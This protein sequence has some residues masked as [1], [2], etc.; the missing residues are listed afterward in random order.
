MIFTPRITTIWTRIALGLFLSSAICLPATL[1]QE[2]T[3]IKFATSD[4]LSAWVFDGGDWT[5]RDNQLLQDKPG[6]AHA[7]LKDP[8]FSDVSLSVEFFVFPD[9]T[10]V[11]APGIIFRSPDSDS[12]YGVHFDTLHDSVILWR[13]PYVKNDWVVVKRVKANLQ[14]N[15]CHTAGVEAKGNSLQVTLNGQQIIEATDERYPEGIV[16][17][18]TSQ[19][20]VAFRNLRVSGTP[21]KL[22]KGWKMVPKPY[23]IVCSDGGGGGYEAFP[24]LCRLKNGDLLCVFYEGYGHVSHP[25]EQL[26]RGGR[27]C[28]VRSTDEG[29]TW[30]KAEI[31]AD[32]PFDD[33]DPHIAQ[34]SDGTMIC[35]F[36]GPFA[37]GGRRGEPA[38]YITTTRSTDNG[39]TWSAPQPLELN[40]S[41]SWACSAPA[42]ELPDKSLIMGIYHEQDGVAFGGTIKSYDG[43]KTWT[44]LVHIGEGAGVYLDAETDVVLLADGRLLAALRSSKQDMYYSHSS[45]MGKTWSP[46][47]SFGFKGHAPYFLKTSTGILLVAHRV[48]STALHYSLDDGKTWSDAIIIDTVGGA[49]PSMAELSDGTI[50]CVYYEEGPGSNIRGRRFRATKSG[51]EFLQPQL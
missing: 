14:E 1:A 47:A 46:V 4:D 5:I 16:G 9:G 10:G 29:K 32:T 42:R 18:Y 3:L 2:P 35:N 40:T 41:I 22:S 7:F 15:V 50:Y 24:D 27:V 51:I 44:D 31:V 11:K 20:R 34:L 37:R 26:P 43:G 28:A 19:G 6:S 45:D 33:R 30:G 12:F 13:C 8:P 49:Y 38:S 25:N 48:P 36:F 17:L 21:V 23:Q 39:H